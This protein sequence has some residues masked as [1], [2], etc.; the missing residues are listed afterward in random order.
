VPLDLGEMAYRVRFD[1]ST[2]RYVSSAKYLERLVAG[3]EGY[4]LSAVSMI[5]HS[6]DVQMAP[7]DSPTV[8]LDTMIPVE[9]IGSRVF[10][11]KFGAGP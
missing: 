7:I 11:S 2:E 8:P 5:E 1:A 9:R 6:K 10:H 4:E 3:D